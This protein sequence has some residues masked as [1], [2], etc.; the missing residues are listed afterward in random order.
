MS[1]SKENRK[2]MRFSSDWKYSRGA[3]PRAGYSQGFDPIADIEPTLRQVAADI[4]R[5]HYAVTQA[6]DGDVDGARK[7]LRKASDI[8]PF[9]Q[10]RF[11]GTVPNYPRQDAEDEF[12]DDRVGGPNSN[13]KVNIRYDPWN[14][15]FQS[16]CKI[17][18][19]ISDAKKR[20][21]ALWRFKIDFRD[22][23]GEWLGSS[24]SKIWVSFAHPTTAH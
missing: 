4:Y 5:Y 1:S 9:I 15:D 17:V 18:P 24:S 8:L 3:W 11:M 2:P 21:E 6:Q 16:L 12:W 14:V 23:Y 10:N 7:S 20:T 22:A 13:E 19:L